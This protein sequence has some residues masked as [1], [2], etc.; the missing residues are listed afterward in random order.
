MYTSACRVDGKTPYEVIICKKPNFSHIRRFGAVAYVHVPKERRKGKFQ[1]RA[2]V[3]VHVGF[4]HGNSYKVW[5]P[6]N[7]KFVSSRDAIFNEMRHHDSIAEPSN[8][9]VANIYMLIRIAAIRVMT[10]TDLFVPIGKRVIVQIL[11]LTMKP[12]QTFATEKTRN[13]KPSSHIIQLALDLVA[14][15][16]PHR[17]TP[18]FQ[19][20][21]SAF[22]VEMRM[23][24]PRRRT[25]GL[26]GDQIKQHGRMPCKK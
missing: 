10:K 15:L 2:T 22:G 5:F 20:S 7:G 23:P 14:S 24:L 26:L 17:S 11:F 8:G 16:S 4:Y 21:H 12:Q 1:E 3:G 6:E 19:A 25:M 9:T 13:C 18:M